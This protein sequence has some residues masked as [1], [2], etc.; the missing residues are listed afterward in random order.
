MRLRSSWDLS[1]V[2]FDYNMNKL[3]GVKVKGVHVNGLLKHQFLYD[4]F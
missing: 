1:K 2:A 3:L 4:S